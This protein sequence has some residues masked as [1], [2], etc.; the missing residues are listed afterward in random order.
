MIEEIFM[1]KHQIAISIGFILALLSVTVLAACGSSSPTSSP[2]SATS[3]SNIDAQV[4]MS[5][6][7]SRCH[8]LSRVTSKTKTAA[9]WKI[10]VDRMIQHGAKLT[11]DQEQALIDYLAQNY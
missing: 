8:S 2:V 9:E 11:P 3:S 10:T 1:N 7:C 4:L 5:Q 6:Q